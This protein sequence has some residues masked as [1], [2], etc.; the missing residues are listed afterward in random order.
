MVEGARPAVPADFPACARLLS[1]ARERASA[2]RGGAELLASYRAGEAPAPS[3]PPTPAASAADDE[4]WIVEKLIGADRRLLVG[5][6]DGVVVGVGTGHVAARAGQRVGT[7]DCC[8][9]EEDARG[10]GVGTEIAVSL[11]RWFTEEGCVSVDAPALPGDRAMKQLFEARG[12][13]AR[14]LVLHRRLP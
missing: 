4:T 8:Y 1:E 14:L 12:L 11:V 5:T 7:I 2:L 13:S 9:V 10:V 3:A 6:I